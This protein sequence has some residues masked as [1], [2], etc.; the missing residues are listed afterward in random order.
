MRADRQT[1]TLFAILRI[2]PGGEEMT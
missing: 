1:N 2:P